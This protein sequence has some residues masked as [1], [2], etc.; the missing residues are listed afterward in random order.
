VENPMIGSEKNQKTIPLVL[1]PSALSLP[2]P[3]Y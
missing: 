2:V 1:T 3:Q